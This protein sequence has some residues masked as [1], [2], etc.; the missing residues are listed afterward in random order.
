[1]WHGMV[2]LAG[3]ILWWDVAR[4]LEA[5]SLDKDF[6]SYAV[7]FFGL[8]VSLVGLGFL[9]FRKKWLTLSFGGLIWLGFILNFTNGPN[10]YLIG[11]G[12]LVLSGLNSFTA[13]A[14]EATQR[15]KISSQVILR[16]G[17]MP[18]IL[19]LFI[20]GSFGAYKS[21]ALDK[22]KDMN[23]LPS[24]TERYI[25]L[26]V[27]NTIGKNIQVRNE[28]ERDLVISQVSQ[29]TTHEL[30]T[31]LGPYFR[32]APPVLAFALFLILW[33]LSWIFMWISV[34]IGVL[35]FWILKKAEFVRIEEKDIKAEVLII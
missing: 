6:V 20:L 8:L 13:I 14:G 7:L 25:R 19:G 22:F 5:I 35:I 9:I 16:R 26:V 4:W 15:T 24:G 11:L 28:K 17:A 21:P 2:A 32:Y 3:W 23:A 12:I 33:G 34:G 31:F 27:Q 29:E 30:N 10:L 1:M 18:F